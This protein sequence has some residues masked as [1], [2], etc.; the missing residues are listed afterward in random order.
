MVGRVRPRGHR[1]TPTRTA[2]GRDARLL[3][4][5][6]VPTG[7]HRAGHP[8]GHREV[9]AAPRP[10]QARRPAPPEPHRSGHSGMDMNT[11]E[12]VDVGLD[13]VSADGAELPAGM[14]ERVLGAAKTVGRPAR[15]DGWAATDSQLTSHAAFITTVAEL[16][17]LLSC[18]TP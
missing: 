14:S 17:Q 10:G 4:Q 15:H 12:L 16:S 7:R 2:R 11:S 5:P 9:E 3:R 13:A 18:L 1:P 6:H 8:G